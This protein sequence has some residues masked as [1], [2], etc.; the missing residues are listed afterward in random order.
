MQKVSYMGDGST[1]E[2]TFNFPYFENTNIVVTKNGI[3]ATG[4]SIVGTSAGS[5]ADIP[6]TGGKIV[7]ETAPT[8]LDS[9]TIARS[10]TLSRVADYQPTAKIEPTTLNQDMNYIME[11]L[12]DQKDEFDTLCS[13]YADIVN[14]ES[15]TTLLAR[16]TALG[17]QITALGDISTLR[18]NVT[19]NGENITTLASQ[20]ANKDMDNLSATGKAK[21]NEMFSPS[22]SFL[23]LT[24][25][26]AG[27]SNQYTAPANGFLC[28][29]GQSNG[30]SNGADMTMYDS[31]SGLNV[32]C[33]TLYN[34]HNVGIM[35]PIRKGKTLNYFY[36]N[37]TSPTLKFIYA[38]GE[39]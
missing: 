7:F 8:A 39:I 24:I 28:L 18:Q 16:I 31:V 3:T 22:D 2:F 13:R 36:V 4:Y 29:S 26:S 12:K 14:K 5:D 32:G 11:V 21:L 19:T 33:S 30:G 34:G 6:Y 17:Q 23:D 27:V 38:Q 10:L 20:K 9:I 1:T 35:L 25:G 37:L 15:T